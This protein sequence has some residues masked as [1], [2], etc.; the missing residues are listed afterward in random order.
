MDFVVPVLLLAEAAFAY[1]LLYRSGVL[2]TDR[3]IMLA[4]VLLAVAFALRAICLD[5]VTLDYEN[6]LKNWVDFFR[7][8]G[9]FAALKYNVGNYNIPYLYFLAF[10]SYLPVD[11]LYLIKLLS[12]FFDVL[13]AW[14]AMGIV[15]KLGG[16]L[17]ARFGC[18]FVVLFLPTVILNGALWGQCD[19]IYVALGLMSIYW[20]LD[21]RP[22]L[23]MLAMTLSF[24]FKLQAVFIMPVLA[25]LFL[26]GKLKLK[27]F[28]IFPVAYVL[29]VLPAVLLG[30][31]F[32]ET[33]TLYFSQTGSIGSGLNYNSP[34]IFAIFWNVQNEEQAATLAI[35]AA[36]VFMAVVLL[37]CAVN[38]KKLNNKAMLAAAVLLAVGIP[39]FLPHMHDRYFFAADIL[40]IVLAFAVWQFSPAPLLAQFAS[41]LGYHAYLKMRYLLPMRYGSYGLIAVM[42][43]AAGILIYE[44]YKEK[45]NKFKF[46]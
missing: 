13:L 23:S 18:F 16:N 44:L 7:Q 39:F 3:L 14:A 36:A 31:P 8:R 6:F 19:S 34:S 5:Y 4:A 30:R 12:I 9:G 40:T 17:K 43:M 27:H 46:L 45:F 42:I 35:I 1:W 2:K 20:A 15:E 41:L 22:V 11:D 32:L 25:I 26:Q 28:L 10:F 24:G 21:D 37:L 29:L 38:Y 33:V